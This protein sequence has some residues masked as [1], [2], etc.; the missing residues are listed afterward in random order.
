MAPTSYVPTVS[1]ITED[2]DGNLYITG[3]ILG[4]QPEESSDNDF[5]PTGSNTFSSN[6]NSLNPEECYIMKFSTE[7]EITW[8]TFFGGDRVDY[9]N[10]ISSNSKGEVY[11]TGN[12]NSDENSFP[13]KTV[14][15]PANILFNDP[16]LGGDSDMFVAKFNK[17]GVQLWT[18]YLGG[19]NND[20]QGS[21]RSTEYLYFPSGSSNA[22]TIDDSDNLLIT[23][24][25]HDGYV[26][27]S[28]SSTC[29]EQFFPNINQGANTSGTDAFLTIID[30]N[31]YISLSTY[32]GG[33]LP[34]GGSDNGYAVSYGYNLTSGTPKKFYFFGGETNS[35]NAQSGNKNIPLCKESDNPLFIT[36]LQGQKDGFISKIYLDGCFTTSTQE[37]TSNLIQSSIFPNPT[38]GNAIIQ[39]SDQLNA[40]VQITIFNSIGSQILNQHLKKDSK[41][42]EINSSTWPSGL[43]RVLITD[44]HQNSVVSFI[45]I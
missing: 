24:C 41:Q 20:D 2:P 36:A 17:D 28:T 29:S 6:S 8:A 18:R 23:G 10:S 12:T 43:Y 38:N 5:I 34:G 26:T 13:I 35:S 42:I 37:N 31:N 44:N 19:P 4:D 45:K 14:G 25:V 3:I 9:G 32:W 7:R 27:N 21:V 40:E 16:T 15:N 11:V 33:S 22:S 30:P 1:D 39:L